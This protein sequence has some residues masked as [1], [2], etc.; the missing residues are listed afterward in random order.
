ML[1]ILG[2]DGRG[3]RVTWVQDEDRYAHEIAVVA[4]SAAM[5]C[6]SAELG[7]DRDPWPASPPLQQG[8]LEASP[9]GRPM[10][11]FLG[12]AGNSHWSQ[13][14]ETDDSTE[15]ALT[16]DVA[17]RVH[18]QPSWLGSTYRAN[19]GVSACSPASVRLAVAEGLEVT[20]TAL[21][22][23]LAASP[24]FCPIAVDGSRV[25]LVADLANVRLPTTVRW[26]YRIALGAVLVAPD[27][28]TC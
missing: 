26:R 24:S 11:L 16:F 28:L 25:A 3:L 1:Q 14:I 6:L 15:A 2:P 12:M 22:R 17:C 5:V 7:R 27:G 23:P 19:C 9:R 13:S 8:S 4:G 10:A 20:L 21:T 18:H